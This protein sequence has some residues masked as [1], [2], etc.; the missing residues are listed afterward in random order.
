MKWA[1][2][3]IT[4]DLHR[5]AHMLASSFGKGLNAWVAECLNGVAQNAA[6]PRAS[7]TARL[8]VQGD[9]CAEENGGLNYGCFQRFLLPTGGMSGAISFS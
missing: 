4:P 5:K 1:P 3:P 8:E 6:R 7:K 2:Q 9:L